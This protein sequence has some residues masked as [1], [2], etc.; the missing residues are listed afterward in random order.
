MFRSLLGDGSSLG[1]RLTFMEQDRP[2]G[3]ADA[4]RVG[5][6]FPEQHHRSTV[7]R[8]RQSGQ[9]IDT[10]AHHVVRQQTEERTTADRLPCSEHRMTQA[11]GLI[12]HPE[13]AEAI[14][15][16]GQAD[17]IAIAREA[18]VD[19]QWAFH[20]ARSLG[21][22]T[23]FETLPAQSGW[24]LDMREKTSEFYTPGG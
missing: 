7:G 11:V 6:D 16:A 8:R 14:L 21:A 1:I 22:D 9:H 2:R 5:A 23:A 19:P 13:Q 15:A 17:L 12:T 18:L 20:A 4:F 24:W 10:R 3:I